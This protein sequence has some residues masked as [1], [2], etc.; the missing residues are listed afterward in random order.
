M[1]AISLA[2]LVSVHKRG[3]FSAFTMSCARLKARL[4]ARTGRRVLFVAKIVSPA[5][6]VAAGMGRRGAT[7]E[8]GDSSGRLEAGEDDE[9]VGHDRGPDV[10]LE[11]IE[12]AP[13]ATR[14]TVGALEA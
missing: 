14:Q 1:L 9:V 6:A 12:A 4:R 8:P 2:R 5:R 3:Y 10:G 13:G 11:V 7:C